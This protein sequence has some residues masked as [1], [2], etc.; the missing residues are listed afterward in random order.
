MTQPPGLCLL[1]MTQPGELGLGHPQQGAESV[2]IDAQL[3]GDPGCIGSCVVQPQG[4]GVC[5]GELIEGGRKRSKVHTSTLGWA[6]G[7]VGS[8]DL[9]DFS[10][11]LTRPGRADYPIWLERRAAGISGPGPSG[12]PQEHRNA[13][14]NNCRR[15]VPPAQ[16]GRDRPTGQP[17]GGQSG[18]PDCGTWGSS[19]TA[20]RTVSACGQRTAST[21]TH[22]N[23]RRAVV[24]Y[25]EAAM[26]FIGLIPTAR[27]CTSPMTN[28]IRLAR[29]AASG[30]VNRVGEWPGASQPR[31]SQNG[32]YLPLPVK[33]TSSWTPS[34]LPHPVQGSQPGPAE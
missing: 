24:F 25:A 13:F 26:A 1:V 4:R 16:L 8:N 29:R 3:G 27:A 9:L 12:A 30:P 14:G 10:D 31:L 19:G 18:E 28:S 2:D 33:A 15:R 34:G 32:G 21:T 5:L 7:G 22:G 20:F 6:G 17:P 11:P 23:G